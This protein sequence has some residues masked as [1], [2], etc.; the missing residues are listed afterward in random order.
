MAPSPGEPPVITAPFP[1]S[2]LPPPPPPPFPFSVR[3]GRVRSMRSQP[4]EVDGNHEV[5]R[6]NSLTELCSS[7]RSGSRSVGAEAIDGVRW[8]FGIQRCERWRPPADG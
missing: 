8:T 1:R 3:E 7:L 4:V 5:T 2:S 6:H